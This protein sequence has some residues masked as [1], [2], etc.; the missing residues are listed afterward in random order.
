MRQKV[1]LGLS[2]FWLA[3]CQSKV[4][5]YWLDGKTPGYLERPLDMHKDPRYQAFIRKRGL[6][7]YR[8]VFPDTEG[9]FHPAIRR[10]RGLS[11]YWGIDVAIRCTKAIGGTGNSYFRQLSP[12]KTPQKLSLGHHW[13]CILYVLWYCGGICHQ[14]FT[15]IQI[16]CGH[17]MSRIL[18]AELQNFSVL[19]WRPHLRFYISTWDI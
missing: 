13:R 19:P 2:K 18:L 3:Y 8:G 14:V 4:R 17:T 15:F 5:T 6:S 12:G 9:S 1:S 10:K 7:R 16:G 11:R